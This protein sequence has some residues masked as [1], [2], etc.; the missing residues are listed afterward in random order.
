MQKLKDIVDNYVPRVK[1]GNEQAELLAEIE[2]ECRDEI[3]TLNIMRSEN[4][5][6]VYTP[7]E[8]EVVNLSQLATQHYN[9]IIID[10]E[11]VIIEGMKGTPISCSITVKDGVKSKVTFRDVSITTEK[12]V[13]LIDVGLGSFVTLEMEGSN[14]II[15]RGIRVPQGSEAYITG[16]GSLRIHCEMLN[17]YAIGGDKESSFGNIFIDDV[18]HSLCSRFG[19]KG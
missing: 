15:N 17:S 19:S 7:G 4:L 2:K 13:P 16:K 12:E 18:S 11:N 5:V 10:K 8:N 6:K 1:H 3:I 9:S 14:E